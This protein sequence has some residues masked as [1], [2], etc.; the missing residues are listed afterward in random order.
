MD[1]TWDVTNA[2]SVIGTVYHDTTLVVNGLVKNRTY[3]YRVYV[4]KDIGYIV[5]S[6]SVEAKIP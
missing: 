1:T 6:N 5:G 4:T 3:W 2:D